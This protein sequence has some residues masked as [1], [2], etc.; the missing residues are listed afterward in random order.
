VC[1]TILC[2]FNEDSFTDA[3]HVT[4][5]SDLATL[6]DYNAVQSLL[7]TVDDEA[8]L[9]AWRK[10]GP[11]GGL[12]DTMI[13]IN[14]NSKRRGMFESRQR[15]IVDGAAADP[16]NTRIYK[17]IVDGGKFPIYTTLQVDHT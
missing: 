1:N 12:S 14:T 15:E 8:K 2:G 9:Y 5:E 7:H 6:T 4:G 11:T 16:L 10:K 13:H 3:S 17:A